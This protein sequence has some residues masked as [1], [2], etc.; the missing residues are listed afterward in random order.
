MLRPSAIRIRT[1]ALEIAKLHAAGGVTFAAVV[2]AIA[3]SIEGLRAYF[4]GA[5][6]TPSVEAF[7]VGIAAILIAAISWYWRLCS[8]ARKEIVQEQVLAAFDDYETRLAVAADSLSDARKQLADAMDAKK[9]ERRDRENAHRINLMLGA[10]NWGLLNFRTPQHF[11]GLE[12]FEAG[13]LHFS[14]TGGDMTQA[15]DFLRW[16]LKQTGHKWDPET[17]WKYHIGKSHK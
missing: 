17:E 11:P 13:I 2:L 8:I 16:R 9:K 14:E 5:S 1:R 12:N 10:M 6:V 4:S 7:L 15:F 3:E